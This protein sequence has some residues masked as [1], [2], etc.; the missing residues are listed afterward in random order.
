MNQAPYLIAFLLFMLPSCSTYKEVSQSNFEKYNVTFNERE[1]LHYVLKK[2]KLLYRNN[3]RRVRINNFG[4]DNTTI[5]DTLTLLIQNNIVIPAGATGICIRSSEDEIVLDFGK[6][7][8]IPFKVGYDE[9]RAS[10][11]IIIEGREFRIESAKRNPTLYFDSKT[12]IR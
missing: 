11:I 1:N 2:H 4:P 12:L 5:H 7:I 6:R 3:E 10:D 8:A 9:S